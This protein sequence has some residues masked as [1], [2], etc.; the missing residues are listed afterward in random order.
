[1]NVTL[2]DLF[3]SYRKRVIPAGASDVQLTECRRAFYAAAYSML[4]LLLNDI[5]GDAMSEEDGVAVLDALKAECEAFG[6]A[7][8]VAAPVPPDVHYTVPDPLDMQATLKAIGGR[9]AEGLPAGWGFTLLLFEYGA[10][11][12]LFYMSSADRADVLATMREF[13]KRQTQ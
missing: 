1:M 13:M 6:E 2:A 5:G 7:G 4:M 8:G 12:A 11:G 3:D 10:G 9:I